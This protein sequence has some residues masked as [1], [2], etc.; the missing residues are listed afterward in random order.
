MPAPSS[1]CSLPHAADCVNDAA[2]TI[3]PDQHVVNHNSSGQLLLFEQHLPARPWCSD[4]DHGRYPRVLP[5]GA[6]KRRRYIQ[7]QPP[8]LRSW[9]VFDVDRDGSWGA[10][11][12]A[13]LPAPTWLAVNR[14]NGH[15]HLAYA[16]DT[17]VRLECWNGRRGP[18][19]YL[20]DIERAMTVRLRADRSYSG[21]MCKN[22]LHRHW[23]V[24]SSE[25]PYSLGELHNWLGDLDQYHLPGRVTGVGRNVETF[26][27]VRQWA[28]RA[29]LEHKGDGGSLETW[30]M[31]CTG[32]AESFTHNHH[33]DYAHGQNHGPLHRAECRWIGAS[34][35][36]WTWARFMAGGDGSWQYRRYVARQAARGRGGEAVQARRAERNRRIVALRESGA[37]QAAV[38]EALGVSLNTVKRVHR[39]EGA[40]AYSG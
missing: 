28:Y 25:H 30:R 20:S 13:G 5:L 7:P 4:A 34:V 36:K 11:E 21:F 26:D 6:A 12:D 9:M 18:A 32:A 29:V 16:I 8:W 23:T 17:P 10:A 40:K 14:R 27:H 15:G 1:P 2:L 39:T 19:H 24:V 35:S 3:P 22:P 31:A 33:G 37:T 38:A